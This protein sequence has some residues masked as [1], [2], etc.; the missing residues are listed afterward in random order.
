MDFL[1]TLL[2]HVV[3]AF[4]QALPL[5]AVAW[6]GRAFGAVAYVLDGRHRKVAQRNIAE[7]FPE[8]SAVEV[9]ALA[10]ENFRRIGE[11]FACAVK[12]ASLDD[13]GIRAV[14]EFVGAEKFPKAA[15][16]EKPRSI[17]C[18]V[19]HFANFELLGRTGLFVPGYQTATTYR[20]LRQEGLTRVMQEL[21]EKSGCLFFERR[22]DADALKAAMNQPGMMLGLFTDQHAGDRGARLPFF[23]R[24]C[25]TSVAAGVLAL[26][27][28]CA[29]FTV[30]CYR[31]A[32][33][34][35]RIEVGDDIPTHA[36]GQP[37]STEDM[38][39]DMNRAF[40]AAIRR[41]PANW[42]WVHNRWKEGKW[43][44]GTGEDRGKNIEDSEPA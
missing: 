38:A 7:C 27:Y 40:E 5:G 43:R 17:V 31:V 39:R 42:F 26:R 34:R 29:L 35:W 30:V 28:D 3:V 25:S 13:A 20:G 22:K 8:K 2:A 14:T 44:R 11:S 12:T 33:G 10:R 19:G 36:N 16:G 9:R 6:L 23:G 41:D 4:L 1:L 18:A 24:D 32:P 37:R 15:A 21:R